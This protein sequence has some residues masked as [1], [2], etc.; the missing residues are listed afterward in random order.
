MEQRDQL[1][2]ELVDQNIPRLLKQKIL[3]IEVRKIVRG[4]L[5]KSQAKKYGIKLIPKSLLKNK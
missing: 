4:G 3:N 2:G 5:L 1:Q